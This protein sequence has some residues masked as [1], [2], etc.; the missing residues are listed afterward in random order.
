MSASICISAEDLS[1][2]IGH[3]EKKAFAMPP[4]KNNAMHIASSSVV[5]IAPT[6]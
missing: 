3:V 4:V 1:M 5:F 6:S 2:F